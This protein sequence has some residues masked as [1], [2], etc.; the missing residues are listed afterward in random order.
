MRAD[1]LLQVAALLRQHG[2]LS[3]PELARRVGGA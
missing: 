3:A 1:R 2:R